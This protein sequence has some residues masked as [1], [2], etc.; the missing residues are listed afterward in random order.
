MWG[1]LLAAVVCFAAP[2]VVITAPKISS[3]KFTSGRAQAQAQLQA[4]QIWEL[5]YAG[6][7]PVAAFFDAASGAMYVSV[8]DSNGR[9]RLDRVSLEG[10]LEKRGMATAPGV[11]G[12]MRAHDGKI[13]WAAGSSVQ[14]VD[15]KGARSSL[16][17]MQPM[18]DAV[19]AIAVD[20]KGMVYV[21]QSDKM[22][23][24]ISNLDPKLFLHGEGFFGFFLLLDRLYIAKKKE[25]IS[26]TLDDIA[27]SR[28]PRVEG[29]FCDCR[30][31]ERTSAGTWLTT[32]KNEVL[33]DRQPILTL[34]TESIGHPAY[35]FRMDPSQD[36]FVLPLS[37]Q[38]KLRAYRMPVTAKPKKTDKVP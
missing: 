30:Y 11:P 8:K 14:I 21:L 26:L 23:F 18:L 13:Y 6:E 12:P 29:P 28:S 3:P 38:G 19:R 25:I 4:Q 10:K 34:K 5:D 33:V 16:P 15:P 22:I 37:D 24:A 35:V 20:G 17:G 9:G 2:G 36:F 7:H 1:L 32:R 27:K 31:L